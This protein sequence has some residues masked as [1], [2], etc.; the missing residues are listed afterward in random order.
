MSRSWSASTRL[1][2]ARN[3]AIVAAGARLP[4]AYLRILKHEADLLEVGRGQFLT[5][6]FKRHIREIAFEHSKDAPQDYDFPDVELTTTHPYIWYVSDKTKAAVAHAL[7]VTETNWSLP[8]GNPLS[9][10]GWI[11]AAR[12]RTNQEPSSSWLLL[13]P[14]VRRFRSNG[15]KRKS[16]HPARF[17]E[18]A[19]DIITRSS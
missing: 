6:L 11:G 5:L 7:A 10:Y 14:C 8:C 19:I 4:I 9:K 12:V 1:W 15:R 17:S 16:R 18:L 2:R 13:S 3:G